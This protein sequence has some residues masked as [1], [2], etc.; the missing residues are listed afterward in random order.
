MPNSTGSDILKAG[1]YKINKMILR[2][3]V[4]GKSVDIRA[5]YSSFEIYE[6]MF[7]PNMS[8]KVYMVDSLNLPEVL[9]I[10]GQET[11]EL[12]FQSDIPNVDPVKKIFKVYKIDNQTIDENG[13]GQKYVL[14]LISEG[15]YYNYTERCGYS[16]RGKTSEMVAQIFKKHFPDYIW[17]GSLSLDETSEDNTYVLPAHYSPFKAITWLSRRA[18]TD[19]ENEYSPV[20]FYETVE[21]YCF[22]SLANI[23]KSGTKT[24]DTYYFIKSNV[25]RNPETNESSGIKVSASSKFPAIYNRIQSLQEQQRFNMLDNI[26]YGVLSSKMS[27]YNMTTKEK[28]D[29]YFQ[30]TQI[31][32][33]MIKLGTI[34]HLLY[35]KQEQANEM[36]AKS[37][38]AYH[39]MIQ[40]PRIQEYFLKRKYMLNALMNQKIVVEVYGDSTKRVG[41]QMTIFTPKIAADG[42]LQEEK[43]D[44]NIS[45]DYLITSICH[46]VGKKYMCKMELSR[47][48]M[49]V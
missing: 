17:K 13:R 31:F 23:I 22:K 43:E 33:D 21:G 45:G 18:I 26:M 39:H 14:H 27:V 12:D 3:D 9:P 30:E 48:C 15:G 11:L 41:Q 36:F 2:S 5:L 19:S 24:K 47:N 34:P 44:K 35:G 29:H 25:N 20:F 6:D 46:V 10:R 38:G 32:D 40:I 37:Q 8:G 49:G 42:H 16:V 28:T 1:D 4:T 7:S